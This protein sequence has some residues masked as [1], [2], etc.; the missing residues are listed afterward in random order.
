MLAA[1]SHD[2]RTP[3]TRLR[4]RAEYVE[5]RSQR[6]KFLAD[7]DEMEQM[8][9]GVLSFAKD[10]ARS[11]PT[12]TVD[13]GAMLQSICDDL[14]D[15]GFE[16]SF[17]ANGRLPYLCRPLSIRRCFTNL[18]NNALKYGERADVSLEVSAGNLIVRI[19]DRGPGIP[20]E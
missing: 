11:D 8:I 12:V 6:A 15:R 20:Q 16:V 7:L 19:D 17:D 13:L 4:L 3:I 10:D 5:N 18:L 2:L 14:S 9:A 1:V